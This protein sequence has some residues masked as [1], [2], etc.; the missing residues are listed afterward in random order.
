MISSNDIR[1]GMVIELN[2][3]L[4]E[5]VFAEHCKPGK[6]S[7]FVRTQLRNLDTGAII[8]HKFR[9]GEKLELVKLEER[10]AQFLYSEGENYY[11]MDEETFEQV[12]VKVNQLGD[13]I[14]F[15]STDAVFIIVYRDKTP[16]MAK[17]PIFINLRVEKA[18]P[19]VK[20]DTQSG[21][22]KP[23]VMETGYTLQ[24]PLFIEEGDI[25]KID[26]R[27]GEYVERVKDS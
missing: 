15:L 23:V 22:T 25:L 7:A 21:A 6:G 16:L 13:G 14:K 20:G 18:E 11:F 12:L 24:V 17:P 10:R 9:A 19:G 4:F 2:G 27:T 1:S 3:T 8:D 26:T 5:V